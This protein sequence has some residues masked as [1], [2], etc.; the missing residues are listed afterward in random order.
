MQWQRFCSLASVQHHA[1]FKLTLSVLHRLLQLMLCTVP[2][3]QAQRYLD[4]L[5]MFPHYFITDYTT[6]SAAGP[7]CSSER[8]GERGWMYCCL[9]CSH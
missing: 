8:G 6:P 9:Y 4:S 5:Q 1:G 2:L 3:S 7:V